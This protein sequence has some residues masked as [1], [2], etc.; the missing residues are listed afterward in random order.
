M[1]DVKLALA[2][3]IKKYRELLE[4]EEERL[5]YL[6]P[7][8][9][10][11]GGKRSGKKRKTR[12]DSSAIEEKASAR[13]SVLSS[14]EKGTLVFNGMA[15]NGDYVKIKNGSVEDVNLGGWKLQTNAFSHVFEFPDDITLR[16]GKCKPELESI[17]LWDPAE[18]TRGSMA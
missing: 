8:P 11:K 10:D 16:P 12:E 14:L 15:L 9:D 5:G 6:S 1:I 3:E 17:V 2:L 7:A 18:L 4:Q 13:T